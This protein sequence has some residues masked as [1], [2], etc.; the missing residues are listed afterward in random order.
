MVTT[1]NDNNSKK[2]DLNLGPTGKYPNGKV[3]ADDAG[4]LK[5]AITTDKENG[6]IRIDFGTRVE[7][8]G[9]NVSEAK[10][11]AAALIT[12]IQELEQ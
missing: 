11:L 12:R 1:N 9:L 6:I 2:D 10:I 8:L 5:V 4:E 3:Y 7:W